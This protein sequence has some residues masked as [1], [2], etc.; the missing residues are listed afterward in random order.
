LLLLQKFWGPV[1]WMLEVTILIQILLHKRNEAAIVGALLV[2]NA[3][4]SVI[5]EGR[6]SKAFVLLRG[7]LATKARVLRDGRWQSVPAASLVPGDRVHLRMGDLSPADIQIADGD[8]LLD[9]SALTGESAPV[10][11]HGGMN[12]YA[13]AMVRRGEATGV[14]T[15]TGLRTYFGKTAQLVQTAKSASHLQPT[16]FAIVR[17]LVIIDAALVCALLIYAV[18]ANLP[19]ADVTPFALILLVA[20]VP[21]ALPATFT[22]ATALGSTE[23]AGH[24]VLVARLAAIEEAAGMDILCIDKTGTI[25]E[26]RLTLAAAVPFPPVLGAGLAAPSRT[27]K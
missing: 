20:S 1:P 12:A 18:W 6:A 5:K 27:C 17:T 15:E 24:G 19:F 8:I 11:V 7:R 2:F 21:V 9:Q 4:I 3:A 26:N 10:E 25:T 22:L 14:V 13:G 16:I 23:L